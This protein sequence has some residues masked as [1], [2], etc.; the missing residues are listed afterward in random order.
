MIKL[1]TF[2]TLYP[3]NCQP[4]HGIFVENRLREMLKSGLV[5]SK[6]VAPVPWFPSQNK[7]FGRY[8]GYAQ[9]C[10]QECRHHIDIQHPRYLLVPK[11]GTTIAP[12]LMYR[13]MRGTVKR[14]LAAGYDFDILD[15]HYFYPDGVAAALL[16]QEFSKPLVITARGTDLNLIPNL[17]GPRQQIQWAAN[18]AR[19]IITV[20]QALAEPLIDM[21]IPAAKIH[22]IRNGVDLEAF[23]PMD[24]KI[25]KKKFGVSGPVAVSVGGLI[26][27]KGNHITIDALKDLPDLTLL[28]A[29]DG[30]ERSA[31]ARLAKK[32]GVEN[33]V[34]FLGPI[35]HGELSQLY[36]AGDLLILAS[37]REGWANVLLEAMA[38]GTPV[39]ATDIWG[40]GEVVQ[41]PEA[42]VLAVERS[43]PAIATAVGKLLTHYP[44]RNATRTYAEK[45]SWDETTA[46][47][48]KLFQSIIAKNGLHS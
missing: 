13:S 24:R 5:T 22:S 41:S 23:K 15:A 20:C 28:L 40:T 25:A 6:V 36:S 46:A 37:S 33:R 45:F 18:Q 12:Y 17:K 19:E 42:G 26:E 1:L 3:N 48:L 30:P 16:A 14:I 27:R 38:C 7:L 34:H 10:A 11:I 39:V 29:G 35:P 4:A 31:L 9:V 8:A 21:G 32:N 47:Q 44:K 43:A 2:S